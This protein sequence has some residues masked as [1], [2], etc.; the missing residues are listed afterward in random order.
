MQDDAKITVESEY[1]DQPV[2]SKCEF[3]QK[4]PLAII[5]SILSF[6]L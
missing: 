6:G 2:L 3:A 5:T 4:A 1:F